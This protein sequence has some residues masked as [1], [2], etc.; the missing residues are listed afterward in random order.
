MIE[1]LELCGFRSEEVESQL[2]RIK[3]VFSKIGITDEDIGQAKHRLNTYYDIELQ[4]VRKM[5]RLCILN[6]ADLVLAREEGKKKIIYGL[7]SPGSETMS[8]ALMAKSKE[9]YGSNPS[10]N[11]S[12][13]LGNIFGKLAPIFEAAEK[14]WLKAGAV[15]HCG[16]VKMYVGLLALGWIPKPDLLVT[17]GFLCDTAPK[18]A[19]LLKELWGI[20]TYCYDTCKDIET[21]DDP[22]EKQ[23]IGLAVDNLKHLAKRLQ[24]MVGLEITNDM[25]WEAMEAK[26]DFGAASLKLDTLIASSDPLPIGSTHH[27]LFYR[28]SG[29]SFNIEDIPSQV[30]AINTL[31]HEVQERVSNGYAAVEKGAPRIFCTNPPHESD[32]RMDHLLDELGIANVASENRLFPPDGR[33]S[34]NRERPKDPYESLCSNLYTSMYQTP[35]G[36]IPALVGFCKQIKVDGILDRYHA[37]CRSGA[38]DAMV[39]RSAITKELDIPVL[40]LDWENF[41]P[42]VYDHE[43]YKRRF[44]IFK[45]MMLQR[46][47]RTSAQ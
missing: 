10:R 16:N 14:L 23:V 7:M 28:F 42:R 30:D 4:G 19:D 20:P 12:L 24:E 38:L 37:G 9:V 47:D 36:R 33:R 15:S 6:L 1:F 18:T 45:T 11:F 34:P 13:V 22:N 17:S 8:A 32:P 21:M 3:K 5:L 46:R 43:Q 25:L 44:E 26:K 29:T 27:T 35:K 31:Y 2:P 39:I 41:D 40:L